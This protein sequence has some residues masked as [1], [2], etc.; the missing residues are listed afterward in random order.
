MHDEKETCLHSAASTENKNKHFIQNKH[1]FENVEDA[2]TNLF[3]EIKKLKLK[4]FTKENPT[5]VIRKCS[6]HFIA[7]LL[8]KK[9]ENQN[10]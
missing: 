3:W 10:R 7:N 9:Q 4:P 1:V 8:V 2:K 6:T 5:N